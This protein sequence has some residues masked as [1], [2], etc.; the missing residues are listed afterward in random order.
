MKKD[1]SKTVKKVALPKL[2]DFSREE[3]KGIYEF[4]KA[5]YNTTAFDEEGGRDPFLLREVW[6]Q[7]RQIK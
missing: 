6:S 4:S 3:M 7:I 2:E 1:R 5:L